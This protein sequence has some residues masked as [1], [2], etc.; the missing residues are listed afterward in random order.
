MSSFATANA[1]RRAALGRGGPTPSLSALCS[2][3]SALPGSSCGTLCWRACRRAGV[4][5][6]VWS[7]SDIPSRTSHGT[8]A[9]A[10][11]GRGRGR[12]PGASL[13]AA[14]RDRRRADFFSRRRDLTGGIVPLARPSWPQAAASCG[15]SESPSWLAVVRVVAVPAPARPPP[16]RRGI[17][18]RLQRARHL[19]SLS[20]AARRLRPPSKPGPRVGRRCERPT[21][22]CRPRGRPAWSR[23]IVFR[24]AAP[25]GASTGA[26]G[27][28]PAVLFSPAKLRRTH[29]RTD[30]P[31]CRP[32]RAAGTPRAQER[33]Q[34]D[35]QTAARRQ[36]TAAR[37]SMATNKRRHPWRRLERWDVPPKHARQPGGDAA[38]PAPPPPRRG[39]AHTTPRAPLLLPRSAKARTEEGATKDQRGHERQDAAQHAAGPRCGRSAPGRHDQRARASRVPSRRRRRSSSSARQTPRESCHHP[40]GLMAAFPSC[41]EE[42]EA[43]AKEATRTT[44]RKNVCSWEG[45]RPSRSRAFREYT[46]VTRS[47]VRPPAAMRHEKNTVHATREESHEP[48][49]IQTPRR[50]RVGGAPPAPRR[51]VTQGRC[52]DGSAGGGRGGFVSPRVRPG[53]GFPPFSVPFGTGNLREKAAKSSNWTRRV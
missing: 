47:A 38:V 22:R 21:G 23:I 32:G 50:F 45:V 42:D 37:P 15:L 11:F 4:P 10:A 36:Q 46:P 14:R 1:S 27:V 34:L 39:P 26:F 24:F 12:S 13:P 31:V 3:P 9:V 49:A 6:G 8:S 29:R 20:A 17:Q 19:L 28:R 18:A 51:P 25:A 33:K 41:P 35:Q 43:K 7:L 44:T 16:R 53:R 52:G 30:A 5:V 40:H 2:Q 48:K